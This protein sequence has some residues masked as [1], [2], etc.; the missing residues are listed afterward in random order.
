MVLLSGL[1]TGGV[2]EAV[3]EHPLGGGGGEGVRGEAEEG[4][5][6]ELEQ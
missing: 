1:G 3:V 2:A 6:V 5:G 4:V